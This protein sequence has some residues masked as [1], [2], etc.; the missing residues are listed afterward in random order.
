VTAQLLRLTDAPASRPGAE[1]ADFWPRLTA[2][3]AHL[4]PPLGVIDRDALA[5]NAADLVRRAGGVPIR[6]A[7]KSIRVRGLLEAVLAHRGFAGVLAYTLP[8]AL[9]LA[10]PRA[11]GQHERGHPGAARATAASTT[12]C[13]ATRRPIARPSRGSPPTSSWPR[14]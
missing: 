7:S 6:V 11:T 3:T 12:L 10:S 13:S 1:P 4:D 14:A 9:W 5:Y 2:A 8:E